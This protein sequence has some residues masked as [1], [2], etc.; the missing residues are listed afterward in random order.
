MTDFSPNS[1]DQLVPQ[2]GFQAWIAE[3]ARACSPEV[4]YGC[5]WTL[6]DPRDFPRW[7]VSLIVN[8]GEVY[9]VQLEGHRPD[10]FL[11]LGCLIPSEESR[12][13]MERV[14]E[15][16]ADSNM[17][18]QDLI[19]R[20]QTAPAIAAISGNHNEAMPEMISVN[21]EVY[22]DSSDRAIVTRCTKCQSA[23]RLRLGGIGDV[24]TAKHGVTLLSETPGMCPPIK[25][26]GFAAW[27]HPE[28]GF[29]T[30]WQIDQVLALIDLLGQQGVLTTNSQ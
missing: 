13:E 21:D 12:A 15:G 28:L 19:G 25:S 1:S 9:A 2:S 24:A 20:F 30:Y 26:G 17:R 6:K 11:L 10:K 5:W 18:L 14:M 16:W 29:H 7:R 4:D 8:T 22:F 3:P 27:A 23:I